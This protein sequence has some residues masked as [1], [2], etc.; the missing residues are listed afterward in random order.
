MYDQVKPTD[1]SLG[2]SKASE[3]GGEGVPG[4]GGIGVAVMKPK[5]ISC[6]FFKE[7]KFSWT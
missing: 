2:S 4:G 6:F 7:S 1:W 3:V 5:H